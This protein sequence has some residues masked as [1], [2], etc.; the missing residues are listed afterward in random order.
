MRG[1][2]VTGGDNGGVAWWITRLLPPIPPLLIAQAVKRNW[3]SI[4]EAVSS[5]AS[6]VGDFGMTLWDSGVRLVD[7]FING[8]M[9]RI[10][11]V[12]TAA[13]SVASSAAGAVK[14]FLGIKSPSRLAMTYGVQFDRG[15]ALGIE[16]FAHLPSQAANDVAVGTAEAAHPSL[17]AS[18][19]VNNSAFSTGGTVSYAPSIVVGAGA[20]PDAVRAAYEAQAEQDA[21]FDAMMDRHSAR[22]ASEIAA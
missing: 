20:S 17:G 3:D 4:K 1:D 19:T 8:I 5:A 7:G 2:E 21:N 9:S 6:S 11:G 12:V 10:G 18:T 13:T 14:G 15:M 16:R 22:R